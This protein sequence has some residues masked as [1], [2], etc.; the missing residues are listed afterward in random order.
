M[1]S[2]NERGKIPGTSFAGTLLAKVLTPPVPGMDWPGEPGLVSVCA[3]E[4]AA[5]QIKT[6]ANWK[7]RRGS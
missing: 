5:P 1:A 6:P 7:T 2:R 4:I 3:S